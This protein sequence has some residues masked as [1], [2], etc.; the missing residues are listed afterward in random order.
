MPIHALALV[1]MTRI[2]LVSANIRLG[3]TSRRN[4]SHPH[5]AASQ[6]LRILGLRLLLFRNPALFLRQNGKTYRFFAPQNR[7]LRLSL[8]PQPFLPGVPCGFLRLESG[9]TSLRLFI[10]LRRYHPITKN[11]ALSL[12]Y[13]ASFAKALF[14]ILW[15]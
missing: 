13:R 3:L 14:F 15:E 10:I 5:I 1:E 7:V 11:H 8:K 6:E 9:S 2:E 4:H 12:V